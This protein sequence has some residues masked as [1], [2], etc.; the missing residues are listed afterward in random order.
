MAEKLIKTRFAP[1]PTGFLHVGGLR[2]ALFNYLWAKKNNGIFAL[3]IEDTDQERKIEG[4]EEQILEVLKLFGLEIDE[5]PTHQSDNLDAYK[6][7]ANELL[8]KGLAYEEDGALVAR[9]T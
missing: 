8:E 1:S 5:G 3:R 2:T 6:K 4:A 7:Y 9:A